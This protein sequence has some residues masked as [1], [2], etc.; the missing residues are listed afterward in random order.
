MH[1]SFTGKDGLAGDRDMSVGM[2]GLQGSSCYRSSGISP[3]IRQ[4]AE[5]MS[6]TTDEKTRADK[7]KQRVSASYTLSS[8]MPYS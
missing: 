5:L 2:R 6:L 3:A 7:T 1:V 8:F 4:V